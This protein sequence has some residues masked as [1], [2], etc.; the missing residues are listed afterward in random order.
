M[1]MVLGVKDGKSA[2]EGQIRAGA[3]PEG[4]ATVIPNP[5][6]SDSDLQLNLYLAPKISCLLLVPPITAKPKGVWSRNL[7]YR[8]ENFSSVHIRFDLVEN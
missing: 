3:E 6:K 8:F 2:A 4:V 1:Y 7:S 5:P